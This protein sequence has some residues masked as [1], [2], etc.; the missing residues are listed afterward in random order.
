MAESLRDKF[1]E[2][3]SCYICLEPFKNPKVLP[4]LHSYCHDCIVNLTK[5]AETNTINCPEC[6][7]VV[8]VKNF[9][10]LHV[11]LTT[12]FKGLFKGVSF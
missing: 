1:E 3:L 10:S 8:E 11:V 7:L 9:S 4:C 2:H 12:C 6:R 5:N